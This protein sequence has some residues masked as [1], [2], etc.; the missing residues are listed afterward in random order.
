MVDIVKLDDHRPE[1]LVPKDVDLRHFEYMPL[2]VARL[3]NSDTWLLTSGDEAK[4][5][6]TLRCQAWHQVPAGSL[7]NHDRFI[8]KCCASAS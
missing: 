1:P 2:K 6:L 3:L 7:P 5:A 8:T 4:A